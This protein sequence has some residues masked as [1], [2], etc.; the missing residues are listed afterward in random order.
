MVSIRRLLLLAFFVHAQQY[1]NISRLFDFEGGTTF[2]REIGRQLSHPSFA[3]MGPKEED[4]VGA[5]YPR[6]RPWSHAETDANI[7]RIK[8]YFDM[9]SWEFRKAPDKPQMTFDL[10]SQEWKEVKGEPAVS[11]G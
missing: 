8:K 2:C 3:C 10:V 11:V 1:S 6:H 4:H 9:V 7:N 5:E